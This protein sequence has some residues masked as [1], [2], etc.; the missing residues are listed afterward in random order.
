MDARERL[1]NKIEGTLTRA[2]LLKKRSDSLW[3]YHL[4]INLLPR[5]PR[6]KR[7]RAW[8]VILPNGDITSDMCFH[9]RSKTETPVTITYRK[10]KKGKKP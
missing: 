1:A 2:G 3:A 4:I 6:V 10:P 8:A 5:P 7:V 9:R